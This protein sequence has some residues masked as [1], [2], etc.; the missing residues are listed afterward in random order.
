MFQIRVEKGKEGEKFKGFLVQAR[1]A[2]NDQAV[3]QFIM[4]NNVDGESPVQH[5]L[6]SEDSPE[7]NYITVRRL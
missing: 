2:A 4:H 3:G 5:L 1:N 6:C 7:V